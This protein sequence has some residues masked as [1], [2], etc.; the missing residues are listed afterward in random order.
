MSVGPLGCVVY[1][2]KN[3]TTNANSTAPNIAGAEERYWDEVKGNCSDTVK[4][5]NYPGP[6][7]VKNGDTCAHVFNVTEYLAWWWPA[8]EASCNEHQNIGLA[9]CFYD[10]VGGHNSS[11]CSTVSVNNAKCPQLELGS[12]SGPNATLEY[13]VAWNINNFAQW[14]TAYYS[15]MYNAIQVTGDFV[16]PMSLHF[17]H[18]SSAPIAATIMTAVF[19]FA[20]GLISP[21]GWATVGPTA[22]ATKSSSFLPFAIEVPGEYVLRAFQQAPAFG[23]KLLP[24]GTLEDAFIDAGELEGTLG[25]WANVFK[26]VIETAAVNDTRNDTAFNSWLSS[27]Y[28]YNLPPDQP[29]MQTGLVQALN[30]YVLAQVLENYN[31]II[32]R[33]VD[34][35]PFELQFNA[36]G[37]GIK[38]DLGCEGGYNN[39]SMCG[40]WWWD[41][42][43][44]IAYSLYKEDNY[45]TDY[46][47]DLTWIFDG[48]YTTPENLFLGSQICAIEAN[49]SKGLDPRNLLDSLIEGGLQTPCLS[50]IRVCTWNLQSAWPEF[51]ESECPQEGNYDVD[52]C[53]YDETGVPN[54]AP[55]VDPP[56]D[57]NNVPFGYLGYMLYHGA[58]CEV[59]PR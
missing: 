9:N 27:G 25:S 2:P 50:N 22:I 24:D 42:K 52:D 26:D 30:T 17:E 39:W 28:F 10:Y 47:P 37:K 12:F 16:W 38:I 49:S 20:L 1:G 29:T 5:T 21:S 59:G 34:T 19:S 33:Q 14:I 11:D 56:L 7:A 15:T 41:S 58:A 32:A 6:N 40:Q 48:G 4:S 43:S 35:N 3:C 55:L 57:E 13:Y 46:I 44:N 51:Y 45:W 54:S 36:T 53:V 23:D 18:L 31:I 8:N